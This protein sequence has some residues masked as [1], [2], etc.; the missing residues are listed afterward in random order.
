MFVPLVGTRGKLWG[1]AKGIVCF[2]PLGVPGGFSFSNWLN[3]SVS[4]K[5]LG[6]ISGMRK[7]KE[8]EK[9]KSD[10]TGMVGHPRGRPVRRLP[11]V[12]MGAPKPFLAIPL[13]RTAPRLEISQGWLYSEDEAQIHP[14]FPSPNSSYPGKLVHYAVDFPLPWGTPVYV[15]ADG[16]AL[17]SYHTHDIQDVQ[18]RTIGFGLG[19]F[20]QI[21]HE[22]ARVFSMS[23]HLSGV[24]YEAM[25]YIPPVFENGSWQ[26]KQAINVPLA[27]FIKN[28]TLFKRGDLLGYV[29]YTGLRLN[30][31][32]EPTKLPA[33]FPNI[34]KTWDPHG[35]HLHWEVYTRTPEGSKDKRFDPFGMYGEREQYADVFTRTGGL[36]LLNPDGSPQF[37]R[38]C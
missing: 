23:A 35:A 34:N 4:G 9:V 17:A 7:E 19:L 25:P 14:N 37:A 36:I 29:G 12:L 11:L 10:E 8:M 26:P 3:E 18:G 32:E 33:V 38:E 30:Y 15:P 22:A 21:W 28:A 24:D 2:K 1:K 13:A 6:S 16:L 5:L 31:P 20:V 27:E